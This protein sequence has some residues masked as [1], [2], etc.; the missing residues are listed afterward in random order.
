M[1]GR[2]GFVDYRLDNFHADVYLKLLRTDLADTGFTVA[3]CTAQEAEPSRA[4]ARDN[5]K[6]RDL[7]DLAEDKDFKAAIAQAVSRAN[8]NVTV[9]EKVRKHVVAPHAFT[10]E[11]GQMTP[12]LKVRR[13]AVL[14]EFR[15]QL[16]ALY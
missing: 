9:I 2:I 13:H 15:E 4:W 7:E 14:R 10:V 5:D 3:G 8:D 16:E 6:P 1:S 11:N 12:T